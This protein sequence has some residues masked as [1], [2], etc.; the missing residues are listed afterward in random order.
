M[1]SEFSFGVPDPINGEMV[2]AALRLIDA[3]IKP[4]ALKRW[5]RERIRAECVPEK[6][7]LVPEIPRTDRGKLNRSKVRD[8]CLKTSN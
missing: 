2:A 5:C 3:D 7:F 8:L 6:L 4:S 1:Q